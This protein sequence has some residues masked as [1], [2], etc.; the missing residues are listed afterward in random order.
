MEVID[1]V[2]VAGMTVFLRCEFN[3]AIDDAGRID[4]TRIEA[5]LP[6]LR[7][8]QEHGARIV[9]CS[10]MGRPW[11]KRDA[12]KSLKQIIQPLEELLHARIAF[13]EDSIGPDRAEKQNKLEIGQFLLLEN[14]RFHIDEN[15][16]D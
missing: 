5:S 2:D 6:T 12:S 9:I 15:N 11:G 4:P 10:H 16:D 8:L 13:A 14:V 3:V 1:T 7:Y